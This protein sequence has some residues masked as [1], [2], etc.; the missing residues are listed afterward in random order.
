MRHPQKEPNKPGDKPTFSIDW[1]YYSSFLEDS[2]LSDEQKR[3]LI[4]TLWSI[5]MSF[6]DLGFGV[7]STR[8]ALD[9]RER[10]ERP[11]KTG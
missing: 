9:R 8:Q 5:V 2:T 11:R 6:V 10:D 1:E 7:D 4:K 3:E